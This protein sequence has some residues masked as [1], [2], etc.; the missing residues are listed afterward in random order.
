MYSKWKCNKYYYTILIEDMLCII[1]SVKEWEKS[2]E[3]KNNERVNMKARN[4]YERGKSK[5]D[6]TKNK[7]EWKDPCDGGHKCGCVTR[8]SIIYYYLKRKAELRSHYI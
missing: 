5:K 4:W 6:K 7:I 8:K 2:R 3:Q 1:K